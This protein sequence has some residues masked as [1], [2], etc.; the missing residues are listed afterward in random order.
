MLC[1][2]KC[3]TSLQGILHGFAT[4][5]LVLPKSKMGEAE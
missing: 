5:E 2:E 1:E 3:V 4:L